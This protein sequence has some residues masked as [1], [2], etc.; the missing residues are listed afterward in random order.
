MVFGV[1]RH[2]FI[3]VIVVMLIMLCGPALF[4]NIP[5][6]TRAPAPAQHVVNDARVPHASFVQILHTTHILLTNCRVNTLFCPATNRNIVKRSRGS[7]VMIESHSGFTY[8]LTAQH[9][10]QHRKSKFIENKGVEFEYVHEDSLKVVTQTAE[11]KDAIVIDSDIK[12]DICLIAIV[13]EYGNTI[14]IKKNKLAVGSNI[15][16][17]AAPMGIFTPGMALTFGGRYS[18]NDGHGN[19]YFTTPGA[20]GSSGSPVF[21]NRGSL[22][23]IIHSAH[24]EF[25]NLAIG[26]SFEN[27]TRFMYKNREYITQFQQH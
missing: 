27:L 9:V 25:S 18:G 6:T 19:D 26:C 8:I 16:N 11:I 22:V 23:S 24:T 5:K 20:P 13:G 17:V 3:I 1:V 2:I 7:G 21:D 15:I 10:C 12:N 4:Y 14:D